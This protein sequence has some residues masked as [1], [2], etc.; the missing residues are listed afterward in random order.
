MRSRLVFGL[1]IA[2]GAILLAVYPLIGSEQ[3]GA[4]SAM[5]G[6]MVA[7]GKY[8]VHMMGCGDCHSPKV[9]TAM[10]PVEDTTRLFCGQP[11]NEVPPPYSGELNPAT[12]MAACN[13]HMSAWVGPWGT[14]YAAN[15][16]SDKK[17]GLGNW[18]DEQF[19]QSMRTGKH[20]GYG[21]DILP[22]MPWFNYRHATDDDLKAMLAYF[23]STK[24]IVNQVPE[25]LPSTAGK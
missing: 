24:P 8:F 1:G 2:A 6:D 18:T 9:M 20:R 5:G 3:P 10:G 7:R 21:R 13:S 25:P 11:A 14:S 17:T 12:W 4:A 22:P 23:K 19:I 15:L 16:T